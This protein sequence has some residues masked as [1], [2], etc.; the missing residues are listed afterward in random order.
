MKKDL[1]KSAP[2]DFF[3]AFCTKRKVALMRN[4]LPFFIKTTLFFQEEGPPI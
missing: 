3:L 1:K 4:K 2:H